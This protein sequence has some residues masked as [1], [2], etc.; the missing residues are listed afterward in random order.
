[1]LMINEIEEHVYFG[2]DD[3]VN[4]EESAFLNRD[5]PVEFRELVR[6]LEDFRVPSSWPMRGTTA[7]WMTTS[8]SIDYET[9]AQ[10]TRSLHYSNRNHPRKAKYWR[11]ALI[12]A[13][14]LKVPA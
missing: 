10:V 14:I 12:L 2:P 7:E 9:G 6:Y 11:K 4:Y 13:G 5:T 8:P 3:E 1:M